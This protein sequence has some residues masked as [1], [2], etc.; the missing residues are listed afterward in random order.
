M[1]Q[2]L[3]KW[4]RGDYIKLGQA[5]AQFNKKRKR[6]LN[7]SNKKWLPD[8]YN[9]QDLKATITTRAE[10]NR[11]IN[12]LKRFNLEGAEDL[13][14]TDA[15]EKITKWE[16]KELNLQKRI[17][18]K[19]LTDELLQLNTVPDG[20]KYSRVQM[21]SIR[22]REIEAQ[23]RNLDKI[24]Q[25]TGYE[26][27]RLKRRIQSIGTSDY[28][29]RKSIVYRENYIREMEKYSHFDNYDLLIKKL[30]SI[31]NPIAFYEFVSKNELLKD[32]TY[33]SDQYYTQQEF[34]R[35]VEDFGIVIEDSINTI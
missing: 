7:E 33:Q 28:T 22:A 18:S 11:V 14:V 4:K 10:L 6:L 26:F 23:L 3:I 31:S 8:E 1:A 35:F 24:E 32:L 34:N 16:R 27:N 15:G 12:S 20:Q 2:S 13:Y 5:V 29:M 19:R 17:A 25:K 9:Y 21:G 30:K